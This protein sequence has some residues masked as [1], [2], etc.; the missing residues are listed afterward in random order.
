[1]NT[2]SVATSIHVLLTANIAS[3]ATCAAAGVGAKTAYSRGSMNND[4]RESSMGGFSSIRSQGK[5]CMRENCML[6]DCMREDAHME[7][8]IG[9]ACAMKPKTGESPSFIRVIP[10]FRDLQGSILGTEKPTPR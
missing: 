9:K 5:Y 7:P 3:P 2:K 8:P 6:E 1:M 4:L 10:V